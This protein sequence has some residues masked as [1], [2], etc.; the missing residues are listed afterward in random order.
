MGLDMF[1][2]RRKSRTSGVLLKLFPEEHKALGS[3]AD[4]VN[5][6]VTEF[7]RRSI[8]SSIETKTYIKWGGRHGKS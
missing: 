5:L 7:I 3:F 4:S 6:S 1:D 2:D 8:K